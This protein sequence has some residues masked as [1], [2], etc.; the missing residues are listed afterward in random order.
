MKISLVKIRFNL[1][2]GN[3]CKTELMKNPLPSIQFHI[4]NLL[5]TAKPSACF[6]G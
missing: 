2:T 1:N 5:L 6:E 4:G 3:S